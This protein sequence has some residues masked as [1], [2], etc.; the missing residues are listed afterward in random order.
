[1]ALSAMELIY[2]PELLEEAKTYL[3]EKRGDK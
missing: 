3:K 2:K 1:M